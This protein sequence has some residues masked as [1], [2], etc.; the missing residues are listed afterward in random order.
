MLYSKSSQLNKYAFIVYHSAFLYVVQIHVWCPMP[1]LLHWYSICS[2]QREQR[3][4]HITNTIVLY[5]LL[6]CFFFLSYSLVPFI[7][8]ERERNKQEINTPI[9]CYRLFSSCTNMRTRCWNPNCIHFSVTNKLSVFFYSSSSVSLGL[10]FVLLIP[11]AILYTMLV[12]ASLH[13]FVYSIFKSTI[14][15]FGLDTAIAGSILTRAHSQMHGPAVAYMSSVS[16]YRNIHM[17]CTFSPVRAW[18]R[19]H[20][21]THT[22]IHHINTHTYT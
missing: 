16:C 4:T 21:Y 9:V 6:L 19:A 8:T 2:A 12:V 15:W 3:H 1:M 17:H 13:P 5:L 20:L 14:G 11:T 18:I 10:S 22:H 7:F